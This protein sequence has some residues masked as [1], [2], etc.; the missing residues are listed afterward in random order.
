MRQT[1][2]RPTCREPEDLPEV[3]VVEPDG[4]P[5][6]AHLG[7]ARADAVRCRAHLC[8]EQLTC[9]GTA[10]CRP[11]PFSPDLAML[12]EWYMKACLQRPHYPGRHLVPFPAVCCTPL[13]VHMAGCARHTVTVHVKSNADVQCLTLAVVVACRMQSW[14]WISERTSLVQS[15]VYRL[16]SSLYRRWR[17]TSEQ[18]GCAVGPKLTLHSPSYRRQLERKSP[19]L[20][21]H[22]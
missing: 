13:Q 14:G 17:I 12:H 19:I 3:D 6:A 10:S 8:R 4:R 9:G 18:E 22:V 16:L 11:L 21:L 2:G 5:E 15:P 1:H 20:G 7:D